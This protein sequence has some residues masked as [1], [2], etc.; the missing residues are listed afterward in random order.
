M[1]SS[2]L[3]LCRRLVVPGVLMLP[4]GWFWWQK[5]GTWVNL[6]RQKK[7]LIQLINYIAWDRCEVAPSFALAPCFSGL[8]TFIHVWLA[9]SA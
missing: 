6:T 7:S 5:F 3:L 2:V 1:R 9:A 4:W 8:A